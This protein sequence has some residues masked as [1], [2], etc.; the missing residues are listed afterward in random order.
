MD[1]VEIKQKVRQHV[2][3]HCLPAAGLGGIDD[4][5]SFLERGVI[6]STGVLELLE[7]LESTFQIVV[8][9][10]EILPENMDSLNRI[11]DFVHRKLNHAG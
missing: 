9:D 3:V 8:E 4:D 1:I 11:A 10:Q 6:D 5:D 7:Y 2:E